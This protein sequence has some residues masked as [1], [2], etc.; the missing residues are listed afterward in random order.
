MGQ[1]PRLDRGPAGVVLHPDDA[2]RMRLSDRVLS[3][4]HARELEAAA[5]KVADD[6]RKVGHARDHSEGG[7]M[8]LLL[9]AQH[10]DR[11]AH[12]LLDRVDEGL[13][14]ARVANSRSRKDMD[15]ADLHEPRDKGK[16]LNGSQRPVDV[17]VRKLARCREAAA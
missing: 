13:G 2:K 5:A 6:A 17:L 8:G 15:L 1:R 16:A 4:F 11:R 9:A 10:P 14:V 3:V 7:E 12:D